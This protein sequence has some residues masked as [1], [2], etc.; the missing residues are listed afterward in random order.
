MFD[1]ADCLDI[2]GVRTVP[3]GDKIAIRESNTEWISGE[4]VEVRQ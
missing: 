3:L 2:E 1:E 4:P